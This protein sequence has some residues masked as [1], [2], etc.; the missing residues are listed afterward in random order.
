MNVFSDSVG[1][2]EHGLSV[3]RLCWWTGNR[4]A[5]R[6]ARFLSA[7]MF[8]KL[9]EVLAFNPMQEHLLTKGLRER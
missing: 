6:V 2:Q 1:P 5:G 9:T 8:S 3:S 4:R 7:R